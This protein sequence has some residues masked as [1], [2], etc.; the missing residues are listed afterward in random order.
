MSVLSEANRTA[1]LATDGVETEFSFS[2]LIHAESELQVWYKVTGGDYSQLTLNTDYTVIFGT[3]GGTITTTG[4]NSPFVAG[5]ILMIRHLPITQQTNW[6]YNDNHNEQ[7]HQDDFDRSTMRDLQIQ[8]QLDRAVGFSITSE[9][10]GIEFPEP[11]S[12]KMIGWNTAATELENKTP[13]SAFVVGIEDTNILSVDG[14]P[15]VGEYAR[16]TANGLEGAVLSQSHGDLTDLDVDDHLMYL[17][18]TDF[19]QNS[20]FLVGTGAG[21]YQEE[22]GTTLRTSIGVGTGDSPTFTGLTLSGLTQNSVPYIGASGLLTENNSRFSWDNAREGLNI[23]DVQDNP[24]LYALEL[25]GAGTG[26]WIQRAFDTDPFTGRGPFCNF[27]RTKGT[28][29]SPSSVTDTFQLGKFNFVGWTP[30]GGFGIGAAF[31]GVVDG[32]PSGNTVPGRLLFR[33]TDTSD[34]KNIILQLQSNKDAIFPQGRVKVEHPS[35]V[36]QV[37]ITGGAGADVAWILQSGSPAAGDF[38]LR[39]FGVGNYIVVTKT[40]GFIGYGSEATAETLAEWTHAQPYLTLHN[41]THEDSDGGRESRLN[42]KGEQSGGEETTLARIE[43]GHDGATDDQKGYWDL[44]TN[45]GSD[46]D[47]PTKRL[48]VNSAGA[49]I[50]TADAYLELTQRAGITTDGDLWND[51]TQEALQ[52]FVSGIEQTLVGTIFTQTADKTIA[53][54]TTETTLFGTGVGTLTLP[55]NFWVVG[56]TIRIEIHGDFADAGNPTVDI[57][58]YYGAT[59]IIDSSPIALSGLGGTEEWETEVIITCRSVGATGTVETVIDW[60]YETTTGSSAIER[61][62]VAGTL[63]TIDTTASGV[64]DVTFQWGTAAAANTIHSHVGFVTVLN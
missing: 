64:L 48:R 1:E 8:E 6:L 56:K 20:G 23:G 53:D 3:D 10:T 15:N 24:D 45:D 14:S 31:E 21:T 47:S 42:F 30:N 38:S 32:N 36:A 22:T 5:S 52:T 51:S 28:P 34:N 46:G 16:F 11:S 13:E 2:L 58:A 33:T 44:Y 12:D 63:T 62:D 60:E 43:V 27:I 49:V 61:L 54:T 40:T 50:L 4:G 26:V 55:A 41:S 17:I 29:G 57:H 9:T 7:T 37:T 39:E 19:T 18:D 35:S 25:G 59:K